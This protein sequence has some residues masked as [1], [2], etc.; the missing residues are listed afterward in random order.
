MI[1]HVPGL[2]EA[3]VVIP[4]LA[5]NREEAREK[6]YMPAADTPFQYVKDTQP[7]V[8]AHNAYKRRHVKGD[9]LAYK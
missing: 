3:P 2:S 6:M 8:P 7:P 9:T 5:S 1:I 4:T